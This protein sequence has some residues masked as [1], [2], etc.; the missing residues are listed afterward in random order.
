[1]DPFRLLLEECGIFDHGIPS[2]EIIPIVGVERLYLEDNGDFYTEQDEFGGFVFPKQ[3]QYGLDY[4]QEIDF[5][6]NYKR[7]HRY[8]RKLR[9]K[10]IL[11]QLLGMSGDVPKSVTSL[12]RKELKIQKNI[13]KQR[14]WNDIRT[15]LK[16]HKLRKYYNRI[17]SIIKEI[18][19][20]K[21]I[22]INSEKIQ[23]ILDKFFKFDYLFDSQ[24]RSQWS[25]KYFPNL[26]FVALKLIVSS[27]ITFPYNV[28]LMR[29]AR[30]RKYLEKL[31]VDLENVS[32]Q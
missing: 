32:L 17:S 8:S 14:I 27:G 3:P 7:K 26:R 11:Y 10:F 16:K 12:V 31:F 18:T 15:I 13:R 24:Y 23:L 6:L 5:M 25:R 1:M 2:D 30:K 29:T 4:D 22:E 9:F 20:L 28:P 19:G 21:A